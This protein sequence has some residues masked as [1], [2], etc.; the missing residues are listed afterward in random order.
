MDEE[1][2]D[3]LEAAGVEVTPEVEEIINEIRRPF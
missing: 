2:R 3:R 1:I